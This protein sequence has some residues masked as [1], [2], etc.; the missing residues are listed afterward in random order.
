MRNFYFITVMG[1]LFLAVSALD[2]CTNYL[3]T[4]AASADSST[5]IT[6]TA[7][8]QH[9]YGE[10]YYRPAGDYADSAMVD[11]LEWDTGKFLGRIPQVRH[12]YAVIGNMNEHQLALGETTFGGRL[13][14]ID[15][16]AIVDYGSLIYFTL[17]RARTAR[18]AIHV[19][20][21]LVAEYGYYSD[22]ESF[23]ISD[24]NEVWIM[25]MIGKG[26]GNKGAVWVAQKVP[27]G[28]VCAHANQARIRQFPLDDTLNCLYASD[29]ISFAREN[30]W[31]KGSDQDFSYADTY[32]PLDYEAL[33]FCESRVWS[34]YRRIA[35]SQN[36][37]M[38]YVKGKKGARPL[39]LFIKPD[40]KVTVE[41]M[42]A[43]MRDHFEG[44]EWDMTKGLDAGPYHVPYR[45]RPLTWELDGKKY[46]WER[47]ASTQQ[48]GFSFFTQSRN[49]LPDG[50]GGVFWFG[51]DDTYSTC[52]FPIYCNAKEVPAAF[53]QHNGSLNQ[54]SWDA[55]FWVFNWVSNF[56]YT[57]YQDIIQDVQVVQ[58]SLE[59][60]FIRLQPAV[61]QTAANLWTRDSSLAL[62]YL[63]D[64]SYQQ[65]ERVMKAWQ[66]LAQDLFVKF[67][68]GY[69]KDKNGT[70]Q[71][72]G[73]PEEWLREVIRNRGKDH[74]RIP[75]N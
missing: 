62:A 72:S 14:L 32:C 27:D 61:E 59:S 26:V 57:R 52:Y 73:Y 53:A 50:I 34:F 6:Y 60:K 58:N 10:L 25:E 17:Q 41:D 47:A 20:A 39:P 1:I 13:E 54:F 16:T 11:V 49:Y 40:K 5:M 63:N 38:D 18:E 74:Y 42:M 69:V 43:Y 4:R 28:Y 24:P 30:G 68:D 56:A 48:T 12:T 70:P 35:P 15:T 19:M 9:L 71:W 67:L 3:I 65:G 55:A 2:A 31:Y 37:S 75:E 51:V 44:T 33:R 21:D 7:D 36:L 46:C 23:S 22:G 45:W 29:V 66:K 8:S 64:Y